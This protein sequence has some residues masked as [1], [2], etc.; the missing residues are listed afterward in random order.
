VK[1][2]KIKIKG[3]IVSNDDKWIYDWFGMENV[4]PG[5][6]DGQIEAANGEE[7]EIE[8][9]SP[10]G[11]VIA[12]SEIYTA[13]KSYKGNTIGK[14]TG[15]AASAAGVIAMGVKKLLISPTGELMMHNVSSYTEG[16]Y[17]DHAH[18]SKVLKDYNSTIA[19]AYIL[20]SGME[21]DALLTLMDKETWLTPKQA[22]EYKLVDEIM[23]DE[24]LKIAASIKNSGLLPSAVIEKMRNDRATGKFNTKPEEPRQVPVD[25]YKQKLK[26][27][28][29]RIKLCIQR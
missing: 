27:T 2:V 7:L 21:K 12:G 25:L 20:K 13:I 11:D 18:E 22:L 10:G 26:N 9:N 14:I 23:F 15:I 1:N 6:V 4:S 17:R 16:D 28:E 8:I 29:R 24:G 5:D 19:N 3:I